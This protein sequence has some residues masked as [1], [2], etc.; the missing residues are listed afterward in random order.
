MSSMKLTIFNGSPRGLRSNTR[1]LVEH[2]L[3]GYARNENNICETIYLNTPGNMDES[4]LKFRNAGNVLIAF[5]L[6]HDSVPAI[7]KSFIE[8]LEPLKGNPDNPALG[9]IVH[10]GFGEALHSRYIEKYLEK[11]AAR[12]NCGYL[13]TVIKGGSEG[14]GS[15]PPWLTFMTFQSLKKLGR[16]FAKTGNLDLDTIRELARPERYSKAMRLFLLPATKLYWNLELIKNG[17]F[18]NR[19]DTPYE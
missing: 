14:I 18:R 8:S 3:K 2:F 11:L 16:I 15:K 17:A 1:I 4:A 12:L 5:P 9:F 6:Y 7:V 19:F 13:G 10:S